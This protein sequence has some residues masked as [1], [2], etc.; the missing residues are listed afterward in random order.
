M[1]QK[2]RDSD[3]HN[4]LVGLNGKTCHDKIE[5]PDMYLGAKLGK[6]DVDMVQCWTMSA[7]QYVS[8]SVKNVEESLAKRGLRLP[9]KCYNPL[10]SDYHPELEIT[11]ELKIDGIQT[12]QEYVGILR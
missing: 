10:A 11:P 8:A 6:L 9:S 2:S 5:E 1:V 4:N 7:E 3:Q 12:Y